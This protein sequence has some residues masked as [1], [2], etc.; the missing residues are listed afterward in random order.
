MPGSVV[1]QPEEDRSFSRPHISA[2][3]PL[4]PLFQPCPVLVFA[5]RSKAQHLTSVTC[6]HEQTVKARAGGER[7]SPG[8]KRAPFHLTAGDFPS[9]TRRACDVQLSHAFGFGV[10]KKTSTGRRRGKTCKQNHLLIRQ[11]KAFC[12]KR[13]LL[14]LHQV[15]VYKHGKATAGFYMHSQVSQ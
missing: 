10:R 1:I 6:P 15:K 11:P 12:C 2:F 5:R 13:L 9:C 7:F 14:I 3:T 4:S 8:Y